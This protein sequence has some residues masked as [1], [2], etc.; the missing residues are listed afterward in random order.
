MN[1]LYYAFAWPTFWNSVLGFHEHITSN[2]PSIPVNSSF[3]IVTVESEIPEQVDENHFV[4]QE[5][6][7][8]G[9]NLEESIDAV[10]CCETLDASIDYLDQ[11]AL[12]ENDDKELIFRPKYDQQTSHENKF[13]LDDFKIAW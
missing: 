10:E 7:S 12:A 8:A 4:V 11:K 6:L 2:E 5:L 9:Y 1:V 3:K 13:Y